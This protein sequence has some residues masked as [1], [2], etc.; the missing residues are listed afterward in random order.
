M[1]VYTKYQQVLAID[2]YSTNSVEVPASNKYQVS[3]TLLANI[4]APEIFSTCWVNV[5]Q[6]WKS[7]G[8]HSLI[9]R[10]SLVYMYVVILC[11]VYEHDIRLHFI[12]TKAH[13]ILHDEVQIESI[14]FIILT[15]GVINAFGVAMQ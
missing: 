3:S 1:K 8:L 13:N 12:Y 14:F 9:S 2:Y 7:I 15:H 11:V 6:L 4:K 10:D 5:I